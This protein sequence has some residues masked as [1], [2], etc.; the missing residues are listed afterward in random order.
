[1]VQLPTRANFPSIKGPASWTVQSFAVWSLSSF[2]DEML[3]KKS[4]IGR[5]DELIFAGDGG[6][7]TCRTRHA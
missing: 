7:V 3:W 5:D 2:V 4:A 6:F 1:M